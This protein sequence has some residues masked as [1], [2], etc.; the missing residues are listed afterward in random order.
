MV[1]LGLAISPTTCGMFF[2]GTQSSRT[3]I[4]R[5]T[6]LSRT[7]NPI[8]H[9]ITLSRIGGASACLYQQLG[10]QFIAVLV[11]K[12][13][14]SSTIF[15]VWIITPVTHSALFLSGLKTTLFDR[16]WVGR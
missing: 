15:G 1:H 2:T 7:V 12:R 13:R 6:L 9:A 16:G 3:S 11:C 4:I 10:L 5:F 8:N 14:L